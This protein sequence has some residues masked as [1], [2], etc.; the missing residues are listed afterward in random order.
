MTKKHEQQDIQVNPLPS[1][2][3]EVQ[4]PVIGQPVFSV[5]VTPA[6]VVHL[7]SSYLIVS[8]NV[9]DADL[10]ERRV[11]EEDF[12]LPLLTKDDTSGEGGNAFSSSIKVSSSPSL[13]L[14]H[15]L[16]NAPRGDIKS[17]YHSHP[18]SQ[19]TPRDSERHDY[20]TSHHSGHT[21]P[22][23]ASNVAPSTKSP[24]EGASSSTGSFVTV[25]SPTSA[26]TSLQQSN[27]W[28][29][30]SHQSIPNTYKDFIHSAHQ[31]TLSTLYGHINDQGFFVP[32]SNIPSGPSSSSSS[33]PLSSSSYMPASLTSHLQSGAPKTRET[34]SN[35]GQS[36]M[37]FHLSHML[38]TPPLQP[39]ASPLMS[40][41]AAAGQQVSH[42]TPQSSGELT[43]HAGSLHIGETLTSAMKRR[44]KQQLEMKSAQQQQQRVEEENQGNNENDGSSSSQANERMGF[45][46]PHGG[47]MM[48]PGYMMPFAPYGPFAP[49]PHQLPHYPPPMYPYMS[50]LHSMYHNTLPHHQLQQLT[51]PPMMMM[52]Q[53]PPP[54]YFNPSAMG[55][56]YAD[57]YDR[58]TMDQMANSLGDASK[59]GESSNS[60]RVTI[61]RS[62]VHL[63][64][65]VYSTAASHKRPSV[66]AVSQAVAR[67]ASATA[68]NANASSVISSFNKQ[69]ASTMISPFIDHSLI[70]LRG[71]NAL[72]TL[73]DARRD[74]PVRPL[75]S[76]NQHQLITPHSHPF[77]TNHQRAQRTFFPSSS[78]S[79]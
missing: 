52:N 47:P 72:Y 57:A 13:P 71:R 70:D 56:Y 38:S 17:H 46:P 49:S 5:D 51:M 28:I 55:G 62:L 34:G 12:P 40:L 27:Q 35:N 64:G 53:P 19:M 50:P 73:Q 11:A 16:S 78:V 63:P 20:Q 41:S 39:V 65:G 30:A 36:P 68:S 1:P 33:S 9:S 60:G 21:S 31:R 18:L 48:P 4:S 67:D 58:S 24:T 29:T 3:G 6:S 2:P 54:A 66:H 75:F 59:S 43:G 23:I 44:Q 15:S 37:P 74:E 45:W 32:A 7:Q 8:R 26:D 10:P 79:V 69:Q 25:D 14:Y 76:S 42:G 61:P 77:L 22:L